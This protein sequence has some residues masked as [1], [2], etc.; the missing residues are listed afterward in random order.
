MYIFVCTVVGL[1]SHTE[2]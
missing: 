1:V 2:T